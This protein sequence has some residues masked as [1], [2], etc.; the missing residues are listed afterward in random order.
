MTSITIDRGTDAAA[1]LF[2]GLEPRPSDPL[3]GLMTAFRA[4]PRDAK[5][6]L[7][8]GVYKD[9]HGKTP[10]MRAIKAAET[11]LLA[12]QD[13]KRYL[14]GDG[15]IRF[16]ELLEPIVF[17]DALGDPAR[18][19]GIQTPGGTGAL[20]LGAELIARARPNATVWTGDPTWPNHTP[21]LRAAGLTVASHP[22]YDPRARTIRFDEMMLALGKAAPGDVVLLHGCCHNPTGADLSIEQWDA[23][24]ERIAERDLV[25]FIDLAYQGLGDGLDADAA[26]LRKAWSA[27]P[28]VLLAYSCDKNFGVYRERTGAMWGRFA[29]ADTAAIARGNIL[30]LARTLWSMP[31][32]HGAAAVR[33]VLDDP[34]LAADWRTELSAMCERLG[35]LRQALASADPRLAYLAEQ[36]GMFALLP[37]DKTGVHAMRDAHGIYMTDG[38]RINVAGLGIDDVAPFVDALR[39]HLA[40]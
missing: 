7:G 17:G 16:V 11:R 30:A 5:L 31:P 38:G 28:E 33:I 29:D 4:D 35:G 13:S 25:A 6:D 15:D 40:P 10:V 27:L 24:I 8:V 18:R 3:L 21:I 34:E 9:E 36:R 23:V 39:P 32:D 19:I 2:S 37:V 20:R 12:D 22:F 1:R 14:G 26:G